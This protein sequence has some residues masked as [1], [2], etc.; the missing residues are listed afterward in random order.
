[1][2]QGVSEAAVG[3]HSG[4]RGFCRPQARILARTQ[5]H[6][7]QVVLGRATTDAPQHSETPPTMVSQLNK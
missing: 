1:M 6:G 3:R 5:G 2:G 4:S 7:F